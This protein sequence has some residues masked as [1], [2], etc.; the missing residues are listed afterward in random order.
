[1]RRLKRSPYPNPPRGEGVDTPQGNRWGLMFNINM[2]AMGPG[3]FMVEEARLWQFMIREVEC[4]GAC[5]EQVVVA[6]VDGAV[7][8]VGTPF[9]GE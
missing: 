3:E 9:V 7:R 8:A 6:T 1:M 2:G 5:H 4:Y